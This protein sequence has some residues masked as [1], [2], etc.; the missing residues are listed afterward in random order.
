MS[1]VYITGHPLDDFREKLAS[2]TFTTGDLQE[3]EESEDQG[4][5]LDGRYVQMA[6]ILT[7]VKGKATKK[8]AYMGFVTLE[9]LSGQVE[10]L[11]FPSPF[12]K[13][14]HLLEV[15]ALVVLEG[16]LSIRE[17][18]S[19]K[20]LVDRVTPLEEWRDRPR[21][22][23][24][25][26]V[27]RVQPLTDAQR[28]QASPTKLYIRLARDRMAEATAILKQHPGQVPVYL[29]IPAE[30]ATLLCPADCWTGMSDAALA[31]LTAAFGQDNVKPVTK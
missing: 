24:R 23:P 4:M 10:C 14:Q 9:D 29:H 6:G 12:E 3:L 7:E 2:F 20:L 11:V 26:P 17:E 25:K 13:Y 16:K 28:A 8:G 30:K 15:D 27:P 1:G 22:E 21:Y 19:P 31:Q 5:T 18:E